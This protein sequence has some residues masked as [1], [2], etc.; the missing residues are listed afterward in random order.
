M[1]GVLDYL[2]PYE[3]Y[4]GDSG[5]RSCFPDV[6]CPLCFPQ[7]SPAPLLLGFLTSTEKDQMEPSYLDSLYDVEL[8]ASVP[9]WSAA[10]GS[11]TDD[12]GTRNWPDSSRIPLGVIPFCFVLARCV[13][14]YPRSLFYSVSD[15]WPSM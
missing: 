11:L 6:L 8:W 9:V 2:I 15:S 7:S 14:F 13:W 5:F 4:F 1:L 12:D 10:R 3:S